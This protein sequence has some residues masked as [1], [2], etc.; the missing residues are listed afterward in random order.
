M[1]KK[2]VRDPN[3][4]GTFLTLSTATVFVC[5]AVLSEVLEFLGPFLA[6]AGF[7]S[8]GTDSDDVG[9]DGVQQGIIPQLK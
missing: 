4:T 1:F 9:C 8:V 6:T 7:D 3:G 5:G 2:T